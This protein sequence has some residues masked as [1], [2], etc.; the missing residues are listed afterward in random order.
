MDIIPDLHADPQRLNRSLRAARSGTPTGFLGD[1]ID[2]GKATPIPD[3]KAV[4]QEVRGL[5]N[6][7]RALAIMGN[8]ELN[9]I[10]FHRT[11][12]NGDPLRGHEDKNLQQHKSFVDAFGISTPEALF[13]TDWFL[14]LPLWCDLGKLRLVHACWDDEAIKT[15]SERRPD[16]RLKGSDLEE[17]AGKTTMF[18]RAVDRILTGPE[19]KLPDDYVIHDN[20]GHE[21]DHVRIAWWRS[22]ARN[23]VDATLSVPDPSQLPD[24][25]LVGA[26][27]ALLYPEDAPPVFVGHYKMVGVPTV[28][29]ASALCL[30]YP[31]RPCLYQWSGEARLDAGNLVE[32]I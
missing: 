20:A 22:Q 15:I 10:L 1:F 3:D 11:G 9:A 19:I 12:S 30:D 31:A 17:V 7:E 4:L 5:V 28:E 23:W 29:A 21:R 8:H 27:D 6:S 18:A 2:A 26:A 25:P 14:T 32:I 24:L 16:G 13:W